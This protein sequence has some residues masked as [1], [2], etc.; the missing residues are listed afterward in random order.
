MNR[1]RKKRKR[2]VTSWYAQKPYR[3]V[4]VWGMRRKGVPRKLSREL[5]F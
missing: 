2:L 1:G 5:L 4:E 3:G